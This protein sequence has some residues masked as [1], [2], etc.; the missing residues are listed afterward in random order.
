MDV[1]GTVNLSV[2]FTQDDHAA[3]TDQSDVLWVAGDSNLTAETADSTAMITVPA[4]F[5][6]ARVIFNTYSSG[7]E[8]QLRGT[9][10]EA[11]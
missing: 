3:K 4:G 2:Q 6:G 1:T 9:Q 10:A 5:S 7:A 11:K 8:L